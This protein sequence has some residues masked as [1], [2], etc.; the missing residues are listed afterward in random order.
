M[1]LSN[2]HAHAPAKSMNTGMFKFTTGQQATSIPN[3]CIAY[4]II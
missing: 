4:I 2:A 3:M 1:S